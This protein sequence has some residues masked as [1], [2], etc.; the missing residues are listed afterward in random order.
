MPPE[1]L[2]CLSKKVQTAPD[3]T[4]GRSEVILA[5]WSYNFKQQRCHEQRAEFQSHTGLASR[6]TH[7]LQMHGRYCC[8]WGESST[9]LVKCHPSAGKHQFWSAKSWAQNCNRT[10][11][12]GGLWL[13]PCAQPPTYP[14]L[15]LPSAAA[16][17]FLAFPNPPVV[18]NAGTVY[19][20]EKEYIV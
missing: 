8:C 10:D 18:I 2:S 9:L 15:S 7:N 19:I 3:S 16:L 4:L 17:F 14:A 13:R 1:N 20:K 12:E 11:T 5:F 6:Q